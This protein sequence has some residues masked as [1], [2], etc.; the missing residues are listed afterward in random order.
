MYLFFF[1]LKF[2]R[3]FTFDSVR[4]GLNQNFKPVEQDV[5]ETPRILVLASEPW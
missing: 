2:V 5:I 1:K 3:T 4:Q